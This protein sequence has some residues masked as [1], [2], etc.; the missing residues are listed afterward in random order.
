MS[1]LREGKREGRER[2]GREGRGQQWVEESPEWE[3]YSFL[4]NVM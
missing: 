3:I 2:G 1:V 4:D